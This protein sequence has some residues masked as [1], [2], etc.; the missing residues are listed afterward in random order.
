[1]DKDKSLLA[2]AISQLQTEPFLLRELLSPL[3]D[4]L[5]AILSDLPAL[6]PEEAALAAFAVAFPASE[7]IRPR[8]MLSLRPLLR[9]LFGGDVA[10]YA[11]LRED[12]WQRLLAQIEVEPSVMDALAL[13]LSRLRQ[14]PEE[15]RKR[16]TEVAQKILSFCFSE[17]YT[18][19]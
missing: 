5:A 4:L 16:S 18:V 7:S 19:S 9:E 14:R 15:Y 6:L 17:R 3:L 10:G 12:L 11:A 2:L 1:M 13:V 8:L